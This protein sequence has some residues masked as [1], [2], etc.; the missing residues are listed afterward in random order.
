MLLFLKIIVQVWEI[1]YYAEQRL[2]YMNY[3][4]KARDLRTYPE[5]TKSRRE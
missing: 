3:E 5:T 1:E 2:T 4:D